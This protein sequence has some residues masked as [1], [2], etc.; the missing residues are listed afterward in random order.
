MRAF[1]S[2]AGSFAPGTPMPNAGL[3]GADLDAV[4]A[5]LEGLP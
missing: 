2:D 1:L 4:I 3:T 5:A